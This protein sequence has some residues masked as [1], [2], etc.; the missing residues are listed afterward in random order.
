MPNDTSDETQPTMTYPTVEQ[1]AD[2]KDEADEK[3]MSLSNWVA[4]MVEAGRKKFEVEAEPDI[5]NEELRQQRNRYKQ[6][7]EELRSRVERLEDRLARGERG[8]MAAFIEDHP[9]ATYNDILQHVQDTAA[10][11][12]TEHIDSLA[13]DQIE[14]RGEGY[15]PLGGE[16][17]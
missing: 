9:G 1:H 15:Y 2:W 12:V 10:E 7:N 14:K 8:Q 4:A 11:R 13:G 17:E 6:E 5:T 16:D 3:D